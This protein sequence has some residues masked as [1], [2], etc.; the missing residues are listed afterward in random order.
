M[1]YKNNLKKLLMSEKI[2]DSF[3]RQSYKLSYECFETEVE[4]EDKKE[5]K[6]L[7][8]NLK[9]MSEQNIRDYISSKYIEK[10]EIEMEKLIKDLII[11]KAY[12]YKVER[13]LDYLNNSISF[14]GTLIGIYA[15]LVSVNDDFSEMGKKIFSV[16]LI[17]LMFIEVYDFISG[18]RKSKYNKLNIYNN[19]IDILEAIKE[20]IY[21]C[22][23][24]VLK[25]KDFNFEVSNTDRD[26]ES[27]IYS[28]KVT[29]IL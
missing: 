12:K 11:L 5:I 13:D 27:N 29:E 2:T 18:N 15:I 1:A 28:I 23:E 4:L 19:A 22:P 9:E 20:D 3:T 8:S 16:F 17:V 25:T 24:K 21:A 26:I 6:E 14:F 10:D 7:K